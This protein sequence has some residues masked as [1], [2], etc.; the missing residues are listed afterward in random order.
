MAADISIITPSF[1][2]SQYLEQAI[3]SV[4]SQGYKNLE[5]IVIDGGSQD[6]SVEIIKKYEKHLSYWVSEPDRGQSHAINKGLLHAH[7]DVVNWLNSDDYLEPGALKIIHETF[8]DESVNVA[9]GRSHIIQNGHIIRTTRGTD[10]YPENLAKTLGWA[11][12]DQP[13]TYFRRAIFDQLGPLN[14][15]LHYVMDKEFWMRFLLEFGLEGVIRIPNILVNFR[16]HSESKT[17]SQG[18]RFIT[19]TN[20]LY[21]QLAAQNGLPE[22]SSFIEKNLLI[23]ENVTDSLFSNF[24]DKKNLADE[25]IDYFLLH[26]AEEAYYHHD[27]LLCRLL[28]SA[29]N[30][31][32]LAKEEQN[33]FN[34]IRFR[35]RFLP[36]FAV[37]MWRS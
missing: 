36:V 13:E 28:L 17:I 24:P 23:P 31:T 15:S 35:S 20:Y 33:L 22:Q 3:D 9:I 1:N 2:Q 5:H 16:W 12:I 29:I 11:R 14:E 4:L 18:E 25:A 26:K 21:Y 10:V 7:G 6:G 34:K 19:E 30:K 27:R 37:K 32:R 8:S